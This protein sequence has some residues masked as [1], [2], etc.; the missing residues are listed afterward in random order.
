MGALLDREGAVRVRGAD[1]EG[2]GLDP[3]LLGVGDVVDLG[4]VA[5]PL[6]PAQIHPHQHLGEVRGVDTT[7]LGADRHDGVALVVLT[8]QQRAHLERVEGLAQRPG[9]LVRVLEHRVVVLLDGQLDHHLEVLESLA[10][11]GEPLHLGLECRQAR[12]HPLRVVLVVPQVGG[13]HL[14]LQLGDLD[15]HGRR[16][17]HRFDLPEGVLE[18]GDGLV[19]VFGC[20]EGE[21]YNGGTSGAPGEPRT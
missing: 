13:R 19:D 20:H 18:V 1:L 14:L 4:R 17:G 2:G 11:V 12:R 15:L 9:L 8:G 6:A 5:V 3:R 7:G 16:I 10:Q 21:V